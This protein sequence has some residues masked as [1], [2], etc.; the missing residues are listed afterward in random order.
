VT[1]A[2]LTVSIVTYRPDLVLLDKTLRTLATALGVA[3]QEGLLR[4]ANVALIDNTGVRATAAAVVKL[5]KECFRDTG[6]TMTYLH[7]HANIGYGTAHNLVMH[8][9]STNYHLVLNPDVELAADA[10][11]S[12]LRFFAAHADI[13]VIAPAS[14]R[15][16]GSREYLC[17]RYPSF[18]DLAV[19]GF[20]P[21]LLRPL[22]KRR[23]ARYE[24]REETNTLPEG[25]VLSPVAI[26]SG[27]F[28]IAR[29]KAIDATGGFDPNFFLYF[30]DFDWSVRL[31]RVT[32]SAYVPSVRV[33]HHGGRAAAKG[34][35]HVAY[36]GKSAIRFFGKHG[37]K[38]F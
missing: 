28:M 25:K 24:M 11:A 35:R 37:W 6:V 31:N 36:F 22:F 29:R 26:M 19:R 2:T 30:E 10:L 7:G 1:P 5:G 23:L 38:L 33:V 9:G 14:F 12:A 27:A 8:G 4:G 15:A 21:R 20:A 17:K 13:G 18:V 32:K 34:L 3:R 16:D